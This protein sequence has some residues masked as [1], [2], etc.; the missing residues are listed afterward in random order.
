[1]LIDYLKKVETGELKFEDTLNV[2]YIN[3]DM[4]DG[5]PVVLVDSDYY[6]QIKACV[7]QLI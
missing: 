3:Y 7:R 4:Q 6:E 1:M 2:A 5:V